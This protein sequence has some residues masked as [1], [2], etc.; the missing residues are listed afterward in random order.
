MTP[1]KEDDSFS[2][3]SWGGEARNKESRRSDTLPESGL[4]TGVWCKPRLAL[5]PSWL[6]HKVVYYRSLPTGLGANSASTTGKS[7][8]RAFFVQVALQQLLRDT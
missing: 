2:E 7:T 1:L 8:V 4:L 5:N 6:E 3:R